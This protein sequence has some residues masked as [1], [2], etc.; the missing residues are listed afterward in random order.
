M[1]KLF[2][3]IG[4]VIIGGLAFT[5]AALGP[6]ATPPLLADAGCVATVVECSVR[7]SAGPRRY[8]RTRF[9]AQRCGETLVLPSLSRL[10]V[11]GDSCEF[12]EAEVKGETEDAPDLCAC[13]AA[14]GSCAVQDEDGG[15]RPAPYGATLA[16]GAWQG[17][18]C[19]P[20]FCGPVFQGETFWPTEC[21]EA[22]P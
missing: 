11:V 15:W 7:D 3:G 2:L 21:P 9:R 5:L 16:A 6:D 13:R 18:G 8:K 20:K 22:T 19:R 10:R 17:A 14:S 1:R 4:S 12:V